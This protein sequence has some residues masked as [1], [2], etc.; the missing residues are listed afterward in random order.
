MIPP[1][2]TTV[3]LSRYQEVIKEMTER[4]GNGMAKFIEVE[5][6]FDSPPHTPSPHL[7]IQNKAKQNKTKRSKTKQN[8]ANQKPNQSNPNP[9]KGDIVEIAL[10]LISEELSVESSAYA[11]QFVPN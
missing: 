7:N 1:S 3:S 5:V 9:E 10:A 2:L 8:R 4:M 6:L 11:L